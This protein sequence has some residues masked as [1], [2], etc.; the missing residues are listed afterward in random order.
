C[1]REKSARMLPVSALAA[2]ML[3]AETTKKEQ[4]GSGRP[5]D[6]GTAKTNGTAAGAEPSLRPKSQPLSKLRRAPAFRVGDE[7]EARALRPRAGE[8]VPSGRGEPASSCATPS[9][10]IKNRATEQR[11]CHIPCIGARSAQEPQPPLRS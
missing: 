2:E 11:P 4:E 1:A 6:A 7:R 3:R 5:V 8:D 10:H 9:G